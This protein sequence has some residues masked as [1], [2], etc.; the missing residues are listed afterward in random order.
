MEWYH[1]S[2]VPRVDEM[3]VELC[4][5]P[6]VV[7]KRVREPRLVV[8]VLHVNR[9]SWSS[10]LIITMTSANSS[11]HQ[12]ATSRVLSQR[13]TAAVELACISTTQLDSKRK[14]PF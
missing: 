12:H 11:A 14:N 13:N 5:V 8:P 1:P 4:F 6:S 7:R 10:G 9:P 2:R 3:A